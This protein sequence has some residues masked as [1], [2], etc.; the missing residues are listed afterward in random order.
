ME[1]GRGSTPARPPVLYGRNATDAS[2]ALTWGIDLTPLV[3]NPEL[4]VIEYTRGF[5][6]RFEEDVTNTLE[7]FGA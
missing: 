7:K 2:M 1:A 3:H 4:S 5:I 6:E